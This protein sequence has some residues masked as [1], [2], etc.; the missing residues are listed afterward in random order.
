M[1]SKEKVVVAMEGKGGDIRWY[2]GKG[3]SKSDKVEEGGSSVCRSVW[4]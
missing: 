1:Q 3:D 4:L 2:D